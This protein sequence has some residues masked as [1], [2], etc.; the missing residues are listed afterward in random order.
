MTHDE[1]VKAWKETGQCYACFGG[2]MFAAVHLD[3]CAPDDPRCTPIGCE[4]CM[5]YVLT[6][7][8]VCGRSVGIAEA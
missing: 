7:C 3:P 5:P 2:P 8:G 1:Q 4:R 6:P